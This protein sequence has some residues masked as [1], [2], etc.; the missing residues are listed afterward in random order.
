MYTGS[1][2]NYVSGGGGRGD[3]NKGEM[4]G[5]ALSN[6]DDSTLIFTLWKII[7][8]PKLIT[9]LIFKIQKYVGTPKPYFWL[10]TYNF[11]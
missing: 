5:G 8:T 11:A 9:P 4:G 3:P 6:G 7:L 10:F 1:F 2:N